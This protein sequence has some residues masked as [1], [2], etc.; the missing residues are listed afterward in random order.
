MVNLRKCKIRQIVFPVSFSPKESCSKLTRSEE[1][2]RCTHLC[3]TVGY[4]YKATTVDEA[5]IITGHKCN[6]EQAK[7]LENS[8]RKDL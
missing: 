7:P 8:I 4:N 6:I 2:G 1:L 3:L 5:I